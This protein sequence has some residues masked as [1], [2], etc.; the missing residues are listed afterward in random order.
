MLTGARSRNS[1]DYNGL[2]L[3]M[4]PACVKAR[5]AR[6]S[7]GQKWPYGFDSRPE[8]I[9]P[10]WNNFLEGFLYIP[11]FW[12]KPDV[13]LRKRHIWQSKG[14]KK[15]SNVLQ[16]K[17]SVLQ[18]CAETSDSN[19]V[20][21]IIDSCT[22]QSRNTVSTPLISGVKDGTSGWFSNL[23]VQSLLQKSLSKDLL[24]NHTS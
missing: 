15:N 19:H 18:E 3:R 10:S 17:H 8:H 14:Q 22:M 4:K 11:R 16:N 7:R 12:H 2:A 9:N 23:Y 6:K 1:P 13:S 21:A 24:F 5:V 20:G